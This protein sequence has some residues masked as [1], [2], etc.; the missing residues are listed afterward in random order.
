MLNISE[1]SPIPKCHVPG[2]NWLD[3]VTKRDST[4]LCHYNNDAVG[5]TNANKYI[6]LAAN[7]RFKGMSDRRKYEKARKLKNCI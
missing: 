3:V 5:L 6:M 4:W 2:H 7:S 1:D